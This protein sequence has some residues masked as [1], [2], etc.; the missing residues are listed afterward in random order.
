MS[1]LFCSYTV[2][3]DT[4]QISPAVD[5]VVTCNLFGNWTVT[6][7]SDVFENEELV[8]QDWGSNV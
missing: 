5:S 3:Y 8:Q 1:A 2:V 4:H 6:A 7:L